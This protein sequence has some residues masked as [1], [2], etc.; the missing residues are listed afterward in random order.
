[1]VR[2]DFYLGQYD[3]SSDMLPLIWAIDY[4]A[5]VTNTADG[6]DE[7]REMFRQHKRTYVKQIA[8]LLTD[9]KS[10]LNNEFTIPNADAAQDDDIEIFAI[11]VGDE[12]DPVEIAGIA[13]DPSF[14][15]NV[16]G[17]EALGGV[18][19]SII[20]MTCQVA[21]EIE[22]V[23]TLAECSES[24]GAWGV[25]TCNRH[26]KEFER[27]DW[28][29]I[30]EFDEICDEVACFTPCPT[31]TTQPTST[32]TKLTST[33]PTHT[34]TTTERTTSTEQTTTTE[35]TTTTVIPTC[36]D[37][38]LLYFPYE[39]HY[40]DVTCHHAIA[41][42]YGIDVSRVFDSERRGNVACFGGQTHFEVAF[43]RTWFAENNVDQFSIAV[44][45]KRRGD[46]S[47]KAAIV[48]NRNCRQSAGFSLSCAN[49]EITA[50]VTANSELVLDPAPM[51]NDNWNHAA[52]VYDGS[53][54]KMYLNGV[55]TKSDAV[56]GFMQ[57][58]DV[59]MHI[60]NDCDDNYFVG[61][62]DEVK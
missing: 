3:E 22:C 11:G 61:C 49:S 27:T 46:L 16:T 14:V 2:S 51:A 23:I 57:N 21:T 62:L 5:G 20:N 44:W 31:T 54:L 48:N 7:M 41:T 24:C 53:S 33:I 6:I 15:Y 50:S 60:A 56:S 35:T 9:G 8:I 43:L 36:S 1:M 59:P 25:Q 42:Q 26:C 37:D 12:I 58:N 45:F 4:M 34:S 38:L 19:E 39:D 52:W 18:T 17:F 47:P 30:R 13:S 29:I 10:N 40:N 28:T 32:T 55:L